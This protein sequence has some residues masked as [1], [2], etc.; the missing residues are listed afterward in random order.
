MFHMKHSVAH[1][2]DNSMFHVKHFWAVRTVE[3]FN[4]V[5]CDINVSRETFIRRPENNENVSCET[6]SFCNR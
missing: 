2:G 4:C 6:F 5:A 3:L 1:S